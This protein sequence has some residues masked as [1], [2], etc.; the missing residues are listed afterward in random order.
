MENFM[1]KYKI[2]KSNFLF[3]QAMP[4]S[5]L[6]WLSLALFP[7][8]TV[9]HPPSNHHPHPQEKVQQAGAELSQAQVSFPA[10]H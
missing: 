7:F 6:S 3:C 8:D 10:K 5:K 9:I 1:D 2:K 4:K